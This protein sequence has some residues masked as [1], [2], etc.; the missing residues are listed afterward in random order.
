MTTTDVFNVTTL[1]D[2]HSGVVPPEVANYAPLTIPVARF[3]DLQGRFDAVIA[4][5]N[6]LA[7]RENR[8]READRH[9]LAESVA[10]G[11]PTPARRPWTTSSRRSRPHA[12]RRWGV[13]RPQRRAAEP[14]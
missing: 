8:A 13:G 6:A 4:E 5:T 10:E 9:A 7:G 1:P 12:A 14:H 11:D 2:G 3:L